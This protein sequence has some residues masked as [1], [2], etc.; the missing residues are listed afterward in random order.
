[1]GP[2]EIDV[3]RGTRGVSVI[4]ISG[5]HDL[6]TAPDLRSRL[7]TAIADGESVVIDLSQAEFIDSS[8]LG[9]LLDARRE[10]HAGGLGFAVALS[11]GA[12]P[13]ARVLDVTGLSTTLPVHSNRTA[14]IEDAAAGPP[15]Q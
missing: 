8:I 12:R 9:A 3:E 13:V 2:G 11:N 1:M 14:A 6:S 10:A 7:A 4:S 15:E 5:E